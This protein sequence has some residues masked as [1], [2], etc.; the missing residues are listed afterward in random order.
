MIDSVWMRQRIF[1]TFQTF[2]M[3]SFR[4]EEKLK[5][6]HLNLIFLNKAS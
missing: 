2:S 5:R 3:V 6:G 1:F 4:D